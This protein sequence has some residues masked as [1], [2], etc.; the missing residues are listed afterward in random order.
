M[1][2]V[3]VMLLLL[4]NVEGRDLA[5]FVSDAQAALNS[6]LNLPSGYWIEYGGTFEQLESASKRLSLVVPVTYCLYLAC[7]T[8]RLIHFV[9]R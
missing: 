5:S 6:D 2:A 4:Q 1:K 3:S 7:F 9:I 8:V